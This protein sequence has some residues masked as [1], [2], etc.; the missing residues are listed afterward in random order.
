MERLNLLFRPDTT[1]FPD[2]PLPFY[3]RSIGHFFREGNRL[4]SN[5][6]GRDFVELYWCI[7][8]EG[9]VMIQDRIFRFGPEQVFFYLP[10]EP[11]W[12]RSIGVPWEYRWISF[13]GPGARDFMLSYE[14]PRICF[15]AGKCPENLFCEQENLLR[16]MSR[17]A[18]REMVANLCRI[19]ALAGGTRDEATPNGRLVTEVIRL[20]R[21]NYQDPGLN[22]NT[23][24]DRLRVCRSTLLR[25]F[26]DEMHMAPSEYLQKLRLQNAISLLREPRY[27]L[28]EVAL[29]SGFSDPAYFSRLIRQHFGCPPSELRR[30]L[31]SEWRQLQ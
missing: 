14:Y 16:E 10:G 24:A 22:V 6:A 26:R 8:G 4:E 9:E 15:H 23:L 11:H 29:R 2:V 5:P 12:L 27:T 1:G 17:F 13:D 31:F 25:A 28:H 3:Q 30:T 19:L 7:R 20:C 21:A 18:W